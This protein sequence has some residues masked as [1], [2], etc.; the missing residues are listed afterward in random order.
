MALIPS[1]LALDL[2]ER[3]CLRLLMLDYRPATTPIRLLFAFWGSELQISR[4]HSKHSATEP[5]SQTLLK[6]FFPPKKFLSFIEHFE[7][8]NWGGT[9]G[10]SAL[11]AGVEQRRSLAGMGLGSHLSELQIRKSPGR[12]AFHSG[13]NSC[14]A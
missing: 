4:L 11:P 2:I 5:F 6:S 3:P 13:G 9:G 8:I 7:Y 10:R 14:H 12:G 1:E